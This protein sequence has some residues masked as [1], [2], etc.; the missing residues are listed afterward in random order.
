MTM[1]V[2]EEAVEPKDL[3][4]CCLQEIPF[5]PHQ[6]ERSN[7]R[8]QEMKCAKRGNTQMEIKS[9]KHYFQVFVLVMRA[10]LIS[11]DS[12]KEQQ[13]QEQWI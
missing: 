4:Q 8:G 7:K 12:P 9:H 5:K 1:P 6:R 2:E 11:R 3:F 13:Q 10:R